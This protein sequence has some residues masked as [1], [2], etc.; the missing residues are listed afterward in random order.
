MFVVQLFALI[1]VIAVPLSAT[2]QTVKVA[3]HT[4]SG[5][6]NVG[7]AAIEYSSQGKGKAVVLL[8][9]LATF[10]YMDGLAEVLADSGY[11]VVRINYRGAGKSTGPDKGVTLHTFAA[12]VAG[13]IVALRL[14]PVNVAGHAFGNRVARTLAAD[15]PDLVLN[16]IL[17]AAGGKVP[18]KRPAQR[19]VRVLVNQA[20]TESEVQ[21]AMKFVVGNPSEI[22]ATWKIIKPCSA[23]RA[24][25]IAQAAMKNTPL[26]DWWAPPGKTRILVVQGTNDQIAP[27][28]NGELLK[29]ELGERVTLVSIL[30]AGHFM[31]VTEPEKAA[32]TIVSFLH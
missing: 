26:Q 12:D 22:E 13:V 31:V 21:E 32:E 8:P 4:E 9:G 14:G 10:G 1:I 18:A 17:F 6:V 15:R 19:A 16:L 2:A 11:R 30:G 28:E 7:D 5:I 20:S 25:A 27:P 3:A 23:P 29:Q 24:V